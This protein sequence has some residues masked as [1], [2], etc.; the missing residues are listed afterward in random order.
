MMHGQ[1]NIRLR[2]YVDL[3]RRRDNFSRSFSMEVVWRWTSSY[4]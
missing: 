3:V 4:L 2:L 1:K